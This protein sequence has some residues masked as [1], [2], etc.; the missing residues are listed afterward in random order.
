MLKVLDLVPGWLWAA[1]VA[2]FAL[3]AGVSYVRMNTAKAELAEYRTE[4]A[5][6]TRRA[7]A[8][9]RAKEQAMRQQ[10]ERVSNEQS[11]K[12]EILNRR[13]TAAESVAGSLRDQILRLNSGTA[14]TDPESASFFEQAR[15]ARELL[16]ACAGRYTDVARAA[17]QL[18]DQVSGLQDF[19]GSVCHAAK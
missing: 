7:E 8:E 4:V 17:D 5:E 15:S 6:N 2:L 16:G 14:P 9:A 12:Q 13:I 1:A 18:R 10:A 11:Q 3:L 19:V